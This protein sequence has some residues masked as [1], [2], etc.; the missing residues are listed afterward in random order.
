MAHHERVFPENFDESS[1]LGFT[2]ACSHI[3]VA[4]NI[5]ASQCNKI[6]RNLLRKNTILNQPQTEEPRHA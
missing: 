6:L 1:V 5:L 2:P 4:M 3:S